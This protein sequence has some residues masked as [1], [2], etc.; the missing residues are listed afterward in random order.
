MRV[1]LQTVIGKN[2]ILF[3]SNP[4]VLDLNCDHKF[5]IF[6]IN[7]SHKIWIVTKMVGNIGFNLFFFDYKKHAIQAAIENIVKALYSQV[8]HEWVLTSFVVSMRMKNTSDILN[9][10]FHV[11]YLNWMISS[12]VLNLFLRSATS[13][14]IEWF[15]SCEKISINYSTTIFQKLTLIKTLT[16]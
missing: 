3:N 2:L 10:K 9:K 12:Y 7:F 15:A 13:D 8:K 4:A 14:Q 6:Y 16:S 1:H 5:I 11:H